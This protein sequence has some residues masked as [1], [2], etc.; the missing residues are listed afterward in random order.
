MIRAFVFAVIFLLCMGAALA[1]KPISRAVSGAAA[2]PANASVAAI[3]DASAPSVVVNTSSKAD[4]LSIAPSLDAAKQVSLQT[5]KI[6]PVQVDVPAQERTV[7][8]APEVVSWHWHVG[9][10]IKRRTSP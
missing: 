5:I 8:K 3:S 9:S 10:K 2:L 4:R 1:L 7:P 6:E